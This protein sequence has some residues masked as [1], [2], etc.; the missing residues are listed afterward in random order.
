MDFIALGLSLFFTVFHS[1]HIMEMNIQICLMIISYQLQIP[2]CLYILAPVGFE[3]FYKV[4]PV[5]WKN[6]PK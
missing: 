2:E 5:I 3:L 4:G 1:H 6:N